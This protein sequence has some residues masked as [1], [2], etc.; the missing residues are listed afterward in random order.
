MIK[1]RGYGSQKTALAL[2]IGCALSSV[3]VQAQ[4]QGGG[5]EETSLLEEVIVRGVRASQSMAIDIKRDSDRIVDSIVAE[6]IGRLPDT[7]ITDSLQRV[8]GVQITREAN[9][10]TSLNIRGMPQV[11]TTLNGEQFLSP[12]SITGVQPDY[13][14]IPAGLMSGVD[15]YKSQSAS[16]LSGG[17]SGVVD[18]R[19]FKPLALDEGWTSRLRLEAAQGQRSKNEMKADGTE[20]TRDPDHSASVMV[21]YNFD[22]RLAV[23][24]NLNHSI[25][26][27]ANYSIWNGHR[28]GFLES[29]GGAPLPVGPDPVNNAPDL[30]GTGNPNDWYIVP[31]RYSANSQFMERERTGGTVSAEWELNDNFTLKGDVFYTRMDRYDRGVSAGFNGGS[32]P[33]SF[34]VN[35]EPGV[36]SENV[37]NVVQDSPHTQVEYGATIG[38]PDGAGNTVNHDLYYVTVADVW[39][40]DF[41]TRSDNDIEKTAAINTNLEL[42]YT[43]HDNL[44]ASVRYVHGEA[45]SQTREATFQQGTPAWL[46]V[47]EDGEDGKDPVEGYRVTVDYRPDYPEFHYQG[48][49]LAD[50]AVLDQYQGFAQGSNLEAELDVVRADVNLR[51]DWGLVESIDVGLRHGIREARSDRFEYVT[52]TGRYTDWEDPRVPADL[53]YKLLPG[54]LVWQRYPDWRKFDFSETN[55]N[56]VEV[57]GLQDNGFSGDDTVVFTDFGPI[58]GFE[59]GVAALNPDAWD[60]PYDFMTRLYGEVRAVENPGYS[61]D[62]EEASTSAHVQVNF[63][64]FDQ[65]LFGI[66]YSGNVGVKVVQTDRTVIRND[67]PEVLDMFNSIGYDDWQKL[68][69]VY[70]TQT[71]EVDFTD[72]L[73]SVNFNLFPTDDVTVRFGFAETM[74]RNDLDNVG[75]SL[76]LWYQRCPKTD[77]N[78]EPVMV[79]GP[80]GPVQDD[81]GCVG[82]GE[83]QGRPDIEPWRARVYNTAAEW[84][85]AENSI[86]GASLFLIDVETAVEP[87]QEQRSF[88]DLDG[89]DR[90]RRANIWTTRNTGASDL[91]GLEVGYKQPFTFLPGE[92][93]SATG[94]EANYTYSQSE[95]QYSDLEGNKFPLPSNSEHQANLILWYDKGGLNVRAAY[96]WRSEEYMER[97]EVNTTAAVM[98]MGQW[99]EPT[100]YLDL[101]VNYWINDNISLYLN[102]TNLTSESRHSYGQWENHFRSLW[103]Q[104]RRYA[105][106][107]SLSF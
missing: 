37:Y 14:D 41:Q 80:S 16:M 53:R 4:E 99:L 69:F 61:Y 85:F 44:I 21:G 101:S 88:R 75:A 57:G 70:G 43:N 3:G 11:L 38:V 104:E 25:S 65:G 64:N 17:V 63:E 98:E 12:Q 49:S 31:D 105:A 103:V 18:L 84:Y 51:L 23:Y 46:W 87:G 89:I 102:G 60:S 62:V 34:E 76:N 52:A 7:T 95:S 54:N 15:V 91:Y 39:A 8:T 1:R 35:G 20:G 83:D 74:T 106:G 68:A 48:P 6:D 58:G 71:D 27:A 107:V 22:N 9:E 10:G 33:Q 94:I 55:I 29:Q 19:T 2:A 90:G 67:V 86:L 56:L 100:G 82:G 72:V 79:V 96:N 42:N 97:F 26:N 81:V 30:A 28:L 93:L 32:T 73:P 78:G 50:P 59:D 77:E 13:S 40:A 5:E 47:D 45:E 36:F 24:A 92:H 66:P